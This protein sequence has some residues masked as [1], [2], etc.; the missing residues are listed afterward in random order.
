VLEQGGLI[1]PGFFLM[2]DRFLR[3]CGGKHRVD[4]EF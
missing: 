2:V 4:P 1:F 3:H